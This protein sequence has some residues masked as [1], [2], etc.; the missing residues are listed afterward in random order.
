MDK[1]VKSDAQLIVARS[2]FATGD[3]EKAKQGYE[4]VLSSSGGELAAEALYYQAYF[5]NEQ[6][7]YQSSN[8]SIQVLAK[9]YSSYNY[10]GAKGLVL[11]AKNFYALNDS[12][13][14]TYILDS[15][16]KNFSQ[17]KDVTFEAKKELDFIQKQEA[18][19]NSS[20]AQ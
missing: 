8:Q 13:Q 12:Y 10:Y 6:G 19:R 14:A 3:M 15:V 11:M 17:F 18:K 9:D 7:D 16:I 4:L 1:K 2:S 20:V 5:L